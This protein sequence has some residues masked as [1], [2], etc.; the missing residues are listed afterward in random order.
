[1]HIQLAFVPQPVPHC[2]N[3][4]NSLLGQEKFDDQFFCA[5][6]LRPLPDSASCSIGAF[7]PRKLADFALSGG[8]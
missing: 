8:S 3:S 7:P 2:C 5:Q 1:M 6:C 4:L